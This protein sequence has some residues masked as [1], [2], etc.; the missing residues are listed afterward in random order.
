MDTPQL[1]PEQLG[2]FDPAHHDAAL[3]PATDGG[4]WAI[5]LREPALAARVVPGVPM[6]TPHT[7]ADQLRRLTD[8]GLRVQLLDT[9]TDV[10]TIGTAEDVAR[11]APHSEFART[12]ARQ[13]VTT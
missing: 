11:L 3:G 9:L 5:G 4:Y 13:R 7:G 12:V 8:A 1:R 2:A 6:S 10:D